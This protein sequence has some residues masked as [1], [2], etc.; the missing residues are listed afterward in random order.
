MGGEQIVLLAVLRLG[1]DAHGVPIRREIEKRC[2][3]KVTVWA[4]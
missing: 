2:G 3:R 4:L 1:D